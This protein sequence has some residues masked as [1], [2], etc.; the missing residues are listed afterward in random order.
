M[1]EMALW[2]KTQGMDLIQ[3]LDKIYD[4]FGFSS[5]TLQNNVYE[6]KAGA[7]KIGRIMDNFRN[8]SAPEICGLKIERI[9]DYQE[10]HTKAL[11]SGEKTP[12]ELPKSNVLGFKFTGGTSLYVRP[13]GTE[14]KIK[15]YLL[16][17]EN[18]GTLTEKKA[19][20][21]DLTDKVLKFIADETEN[22]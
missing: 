17:Q 19:K 21:K 16:I 4:Q 22:A 11:A 5:E 7:E 20:A 12:I 2:Y 13:S 18:E 9:E 10:G 15:F 14:P 3:A 1:A 8:F 6:G